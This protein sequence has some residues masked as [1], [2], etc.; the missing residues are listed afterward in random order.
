M[1]EVDIIKNRLASQQLAQTNL[2]TPAEMVRWM[3]AVQAQDYSA[4]KWALGL[5]LSR[6][7]DAE[8]EQA[9]NEGKI[10]RTHILRPTWHFVAPEDIRWM[11]ALTAPRV[12]QAISS[13]YRKL[14][15]N[16]AIFKK[17]NSIIVKALS[18]G[19]QLTRAE[20][21]AKHE[22]A[23]IST[24]D[25]RS[26]HLMFHAELSATVCSG[27]RRDKQFTYA[28]FEE[29]VPP[30]KTM[31]CEESLA[32]L[33][34]RYFESHGAATLKDFVWWSGLT[35]SEAKAGIMAVESYLSTEKINGKEFYFADSS[36]TMR[37]PDAVYLLPCFDEYTVAFKDRSIIYDQQKI[38]KINSR[39]DAISNNVV[40]IKGRIAGIWKRI[41]KKNSVAFE[42]S[43]LDSV[44]DREKRAVIRAARKYAD[45]FD[46]TLAENEIT[47]RSTAA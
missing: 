46:K 26:S 42:I 4:A 22:E 15:L 18:G 35:V 19:K 25:L 5:R 29:R 21:M 8:I 30:G 10:L 37:L 24:N 28:L 12:N 1:T 2:K 7:S 17:S 41:L 9:F 11:L 36:P 16:E 43:L 34:R 45:F 47:F 14:E 6:S 3:G 40:V 39:G 44:N 32:E 38:G 20:L 13:Y 31:T 27:A 23:G 33:T